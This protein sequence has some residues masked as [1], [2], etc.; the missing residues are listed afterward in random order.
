MRRWDHDA[1]DLS[2]SDEGALLVTESATGDDGWLELEDGVL[3]QFPASTV[4]GGPIEYRTG[5]YWLIPARTATGD[6]IW[7]RRLVGDHLVWQAKP[8]NGPMHHYAPLTIATMSDRDEL[9]VDLPDC[10]C[11]FSPLPC[12]PGI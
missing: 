11:R 9:T 4:A 8:P 1:S 12:E 2:N 6:V 10:R 5:D 3:V 7:P